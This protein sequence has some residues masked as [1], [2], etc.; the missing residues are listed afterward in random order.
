[1]LRSVIKVWSISRRFRNGH[2]SKFN[3]DKLVLEASSISI[4]I[5]L[6]AFNSFNYELFALR[7]LSFCK[8]SVAIL[9]IA[10]SLHV[11]I[12]KLTI[13]DK[14]MNVNLVP[15]TENYVNWS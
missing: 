5:R 7:I 10:V 14:S 11:K 1:M 13:Y 15:E 2:L 3:M 9:C 8:L 12:C 4:D 6:I